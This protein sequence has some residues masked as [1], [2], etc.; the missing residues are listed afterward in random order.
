MLNV[1]NYRG[2]ADHIS[3]K[4]NDDKCGKGCGEKE[5][6]EHYRWAYN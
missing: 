6:L 5:T 2:N 4:I 3:M 1:T